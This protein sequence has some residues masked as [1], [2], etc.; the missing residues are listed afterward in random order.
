MG[1]AAFNV[2]AV[3]VSPECSTGRKILGCDKPYFLLNGYTISDDEILVDMRAAEDANVFNDYLRT[4]YSDLC[5]NI[6]AVAG[7]NGSGKSSLVEFMMRLLNNFSA[8]FMACADD[9]IQRD[10]HLKFIPGVCGELF[11][12]LRGV[13]HII[14]VGDEWI[15]LHSYH[16]VNK[17]DS[18]VTFH[19][20]RVPLF[21]F[22]PR[23]RRRVTTDGNRDA[24]KDIISSSFFFSCFSNYS[25]YAYN[26]EDFGDEK[27]VSLNNRHEDRDGW[28]SH[29][30]HKNDGYQT[31]IV[32][33]PFREKGNI[34]VNKESRLAKYRLIALLISNH[35]INCF[36]GHLRIRELR[37][38]FIPGYHGLDYFRKMSGKNLREGDFRKIRQRV[39][40]CWSEAYSARFKNDINPVKLETALDYLAVKTLKASLYYGEYFS[41]FGRIIDQEGGPAEGYE[42]AVKELV[43]ALSLD[44]SHITTKIRQTLCFLTR[45]SF[46]SDRVSIE[47]ARRVCANSMHS[48]K[49]DYRMQLPMMFAKR[50]DVLPA[51]FFKA[52]PIFE[53]NNG[54]MV[55]LDKLSSGERQQI[56]SVTSVLY[57]LGNIDSVHEDKNGRRI[58]YGNAL[59]VLE[60]IEL[61]YHPQ[62]QREFI[63]YLLDGLRQMNFAG[64]KGVSLLI[65]THSP[66][67]LGDI[68]PG[69]IL[70]LGEGAV[71]VPRIDSFGAN[72][73]DML[74]T[75]F[76][77]HDGSRGK[78]AEWMI[79]RILLDLRNRKKMLTRRQ[80]RL[81][82]SRIMLIDD[83]LI[84]AIL[85]DEFHRRLGD[86]DR[87]GRIAELHRQIEDLERGE[88]RPGERR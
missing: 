74:N 1:L 48:M 64:L 52:T 53:E 54:A 81:L 30:F 29:L 32:L 61:Y 65:V 80:K 69:N 33:F 83:P 78:F 35:D 77:M 25:L 58:A 7:A 63:L 31:P 10:C 28:I 70:A 20:E 88:P 13:P 12:M 26:S 3:R 68:P 71:P 38:E 79:G 66:F 45:R 16:A 47:T 21:E 72:I 9:Y 44:H 49:E 34:D 18:S 8:A 62:L 67:V 73:H 59:V 27:S 41:I 86:P 51:P 5:V 17:S 60:E 84:R 75:A 37:L 40:E 24:I 76:F 57:H 43:D 87:E 85:T 11:F 2:F 39:A 22:D 36:N 14:S 4:H 82:H 23:S 46:D 56:Y 6:S 19:K 50:E 42:V 55:G 15:L